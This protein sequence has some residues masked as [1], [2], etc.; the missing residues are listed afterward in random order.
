[1][2]TLETR[3]A[4]IAQELTFVGDWTDRY[5]LLVEWGEEAEALPEADRLPEWEVSGCSSPLWLRVQWSDDRLEVQGASPGILPQALVALVGRL[6][7][8]LEDVHGSD[9][10]IVERLELGK[11]LSPTRLLVFKRMLDRALHCP[12]TAP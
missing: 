7:D 11:N 8:G 1:M 10:Q 12:R 5:R 4:D 9:S 2:E 6:F 3:L